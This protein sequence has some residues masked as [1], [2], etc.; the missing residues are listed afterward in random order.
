MMEQ[1]NSLE[2]TWQLL[3]IH[4]TPTALVS[5]STLSC[6]RTNLAFEELTG[7]SLESEISVRDLV[8]PEDVPNLDLN[9]RLV[10]V[11]QRDSGYC[12]CEL[13]WQQVSDRQHL[14]T[15]LPASSPS[16]DL[17]IL[18]VFPGIAIIVFDKDY[19]YLMA[20]G[21][22]L[23]DAALNDVAIVGKTIYDVLPP[24]HI[25]FFEPFYGDVFAGISNHLERTINNKVFDMYFRPIFDQ[26]GHIKAGMILNTD[27]SQQRLAEQ[28]L[29]DSVTLNQA[30]LDA[31]P[32]ILLRLDSG[33]YLKD[34]FTRDSNDLMVHGSKVVGNH[35]STIFSEKMVT[36]ML[37]DLQL[38]LSKKTLHN[39][40]YEVHGSFSELRIVPFKEDEVLCLIRNVT[41]R[42]RMEMALRESERRYRE[43]F[44]GI[45]D[46]IIVHDLRG[47]ILDVN[48]LT[49]ERLELSRQELLR[50]S[51]FDLADVNYIEGIHQELKS[52]TDP[53]NLHISDT[54][55]LTLHGHQDHDVNTKLITYRDRPAILAVYRDISDRTMAEAALRESEKRFRLLA[56]TIEDVF[57]I[58]SL[59]FAETYYV[60][61]AFEK[62][63]GISLDDYYKNPRCVLDS[64]HV[65]DQDEYK[66]VFHSKKN[67][68]MREY[69]IVRPDTN[70]RWIRER[71]YRIYDDEGNPYQVVSIASDITE[72]KRIAHLKAAG[73]ISVGVAHQINNPLTTVI[74]QS[75]RIMNKIEPEH[76]LHE[77]A[78]DT[79]TAAN[80]AAQIV[81]RLLNLARGSLGEMRRI[82]INDSVQAAVKLLRPQIEPDAAQIILDLKRDLPPVWGNDDYLQDVWTNLLLNARDAIVENDRKGVIKVGSVLNQTK[83]MIEVTVYDNGV[84]ITSDEL[85]HIFKPFISSKAHGTG[86]GLAICHDIITRHQGFINVY[87]RENYG[88][89][90]SIMLPVST[91]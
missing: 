61:P 28:A 34:I 57:W 45:N 12:L 7:I 53:H 4:P 55:R 23:D 71:G 20:T 47:N 73:E 80:Q 82:D 14:L 83:R 42:K 68:W 35:I 58:H 24:D 31:L 62:V 76:P 66:S 64:V 46:I 3:N 40:E 60:S 39:A 86:L 6:Q 85:D 51:I 1:Q 32:D 18:N 52:Q 77:A 13:T 48:E 54:V 11:Q 2:S 81:Q 19:R 10:R 21:G 17:D 63:W 44:E 70:Q 27:I 30:I 74:V 69:R 50:T 84:G 87:S 65:Q 78:Q 22:A 90:F 33:G 56:E 43:L 41:E 26:D 16:I 59:D 67:Q 38:V 72:E 49:C 5:T 91:T 37:E 79:Y 8:H 15:I 29:L 89:I 25:E 9:S 36:R 88:T 75:N